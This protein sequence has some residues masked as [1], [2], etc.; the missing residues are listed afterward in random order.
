MPRRRSVMA[1]DDGSFFIHCRND[2]LLLIPSKGNRNRRLKIS[3]EV[4][5]V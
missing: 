3:V 2:V 4:L 5:G 1:R